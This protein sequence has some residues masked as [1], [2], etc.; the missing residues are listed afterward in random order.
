MDFKNHY[1]FD[2]M[3]RDLYPLTYYIEAPIVILCEI[4]LIA[5]SLIRGIPDFHVGI[6]FAIVTGVILASIII[7]YH[8]KPLLKKEAQAMYF[9]SPSSALSKAVLQYERL[10]AAT[11]PD[12]F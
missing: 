12:Y 8:A 6:S 11:M 5:M 4:F 9:F 7:A 1:V 3:L 2:K 10:G